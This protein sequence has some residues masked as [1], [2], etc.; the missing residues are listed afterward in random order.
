MKSIFNITYFI[1]SCLDRQLKQFRYFILKTFFIIFFKAVIRNVNRK[2][3]C[4]GMSGSCEMQTCW[5]ATPDFKEV[6]NRLKRKY[7][8]A[9]K[10]KVNVLC[11]N[12]LPVNDQASHFLFRP[13][14][15]YAQ[16]R[17]QGKKNVFIW[18]LTFGKNYYQY[19][20]PVK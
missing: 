13:R 19:G 4:H 5:K 7:R 20:K 2:C 12:F 14:H 17:Y 16:K 3:K 1:K 9:R 8:S 10:V 11:C 6:G 15:F 18:I